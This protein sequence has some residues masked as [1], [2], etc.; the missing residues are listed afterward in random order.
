MR[1][2]EEIL[3]RFLASFPETDFA[4][5]RP[6]IE[7]RDSFV[8]TSQS[9]SSDQG[10]PDILRVQVRVAEVAPGPVWVETL[11][12]R[13]E[14]LDYFYFMIYSITTT[15][16]G[17][18]KPATPFAKAVASLAN[19]YEV[20]FLII[21]TNLVVARSFAK[22]A[23]DAKHPCRYLHEKADQSSANQASE[24]PTLPAPTSNNGEPGT[25]R[26]SL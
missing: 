19:L 18:I 26:A 25:S 21:L 15:G 20:F 8:D 13:P 23:E 2:R 9:E 12:I 11:A 14:L 6:T 4:D 22:N 1:V 17:D 16:Y 24:V 3:N 10:R 5:Q 7:W